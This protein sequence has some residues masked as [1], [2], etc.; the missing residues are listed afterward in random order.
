[1]PPEAF[2]TLRRGLEER[3][4]TPAQAEV[5]LL[6]KTLTPL[7][8]RAAEQTLRL[9]DRLEELDD[10]QRS[11]PTGTSPWQ[12]WSATGPRRSS[13]TERV[14]GID[15][16]T[17]RMGYGLVESSGHQPRYLAS[18]ALVPPRS[19]PLGERLWE[20]FQELTKLLDTWEPTTVAVEEPYVPRTRADG[21]GSSVRSAMALG[22]A[23]ALV[24]IAAAARGIPVTATPPPRSRAQ[25]RMTAEARRSRCRRWCA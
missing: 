19:H 18:G 24:L 9:L 16:G 10:V 22:Q 13:M 7:D 4:H 8:E 2:E 17:L 21:T 11:T 12:S 25:S 6:P 23:E 5:T 20:L 14:L 1:M 15:P 3:G